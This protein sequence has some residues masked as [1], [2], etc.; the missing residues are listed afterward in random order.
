MRNPYPQRRRP[1]VS[2]R[3]LWRLVVMRHTC[4]LRRID[5]VSERHLWLRGVMHIAALKGE[6]HGC[7]KALPLAARGDAK[8]ELYAAL[9]PRFRALPLAAQGDAYARQR[10]PQAGVSERCLWRR[11]VMLIPWQA[12]VKAGD[13]RHVST[14]EER[15]RHLRFKIRY[16]SQIK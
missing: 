13:F 12:L 5:D 15:F 9:A 16:F 1:R 14:H 4:T 3:C 7:F 11:G 2:E 10:K 6:D 8:A